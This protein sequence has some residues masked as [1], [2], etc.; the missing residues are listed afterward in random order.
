MDGI[1]QRI[2]TEANRSERL[3]VAREEFLAEFLAQTCARRALGILNLP[4]TNN[5][6]SRLAA[7]IK[8]ESNDTGLSLEDSANRMTQA[9]S[10]DRQR[11]VKIDI[12]YFEDVKWRSNVRLDKAEQRK[13]DNL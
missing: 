3:G 11:G 2:A 5:L 7:V 13:L 10:E 1:V 8:A 12:F 6:V 9:A 4:V